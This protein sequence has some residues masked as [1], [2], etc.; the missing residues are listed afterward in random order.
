MRRLRWIGIRL[1]IFL[2]VR[3]GETPVEVAQPDAFSFALL[4]VADVNDLVRLEPG[5]DCR[6]L[7]NWFQEG[8]LCYGIWDQSRLIAK[9]WC[10]LDEFN[11]PPNYRRLD[12]DE[13]YL[14]AAF[15]DPDYRGQSLAPLMRAKGYEALRELGRNR[16]Y[17]YTDFFNTA[18]RR[19][20]VKLGA[21]N[22]LLRMHLELFGKWSK[23]FTLRRY[24]I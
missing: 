14:Y 4:T 11:Y 5:T 12:A 20:K 10:D 6:E 17:S 7:I 15:A 24:G 19:F 9:M 22:E 16:F 23:T 18:A 2:T 1:E 21:R 13:V 8:K 3:E